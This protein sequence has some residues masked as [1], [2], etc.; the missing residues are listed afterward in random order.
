MVLE[1]ETNV[2]VE[3]TIALLQHGLRAAMTEGY[4]DVLVR[5]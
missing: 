2:L 5:A 1:E 3:G 4:A